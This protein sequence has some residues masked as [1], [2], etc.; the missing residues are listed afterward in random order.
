M[1]TDS[2]PRVAILDDYQGVALTSADWSHLKGRVN[3]DV[4]RDTLLEED[5]LARR[6]QPYDIIC[7]MRERT[8]FPSSLFDKLPNLKSVL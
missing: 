6:L 1:S 2:L 8:K 4:Y 7:A 5:Q 3:I